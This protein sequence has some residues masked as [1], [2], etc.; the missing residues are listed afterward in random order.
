MMFSIPSPDILAYYSSPGVTTDPTENGYLLDSLPTEI[1]ELCQLVQNNLL[2]VFWSERYGRVLS[3]EEKYTVG[4]R[5]V[6][7]KLEIL[8]QSDPRPLTAPRTL[9][10]R[11]IGN[12]RD[13]TVM[14]TSILRHQGTP[15]R[16]RCGFG[17]YFLPNHYE[18]HWV[19][20]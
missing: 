11:Q 4:V 12:C 9:D 2:H 14:I 5:S 18:D 6:A 19:C 10:G 8:R 20:E 1:G 7:K 13:F 16:A 3:E 17:A 15:A